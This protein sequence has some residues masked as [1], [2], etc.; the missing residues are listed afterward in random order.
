MI[1]I[2]DGGISTQV[3][4]IQNN[5]VTVE[6]LNHGKIGSKKNMCLPGCVINLPTIGEVDK[7]DIINFGV[8]NKIDFIAISFARYKKDLDDLRKLLVQKDP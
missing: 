5:I 8:V 6:V 2:A 3:V 4:K 1:L 7:N